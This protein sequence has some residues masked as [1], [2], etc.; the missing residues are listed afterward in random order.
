MRSH[1]QVTLVA[2]VIALGIN[3]RL[4]GA[5]TPLPY[6]DARLSTADR[7]RD[8]LGRMT[9]E[10]KFW[11]LFMIPGDLD[12]ASYDYS[13]RIFGLQISPADSARDNAARRHAERVNT[14]Q[15]YF[16]DRTR[17]G[18]P[19]IPFDE[20]LHGFVREGA[21]AF[22]QAI[23]LAATW[24]TALM[25]RVADAIAR[26]T[27]S[28]GVRQI[29]SPVINVANDVRWGRVEETY[30]EDPYLTSAMGQ[31]FIRPFE[32][33]GVITTAK[34]FI[35]NVGEGG[36]DSY[37]IDINERTLEELF[38]PPFRD[39]I[40]KA[41]GRSVMTAYNSVDGLPATQN[42]ALLNGKL[43]GDWGLQ[44]FVISD[45]AATGGATVLHYTEASTA[46]AVKDALDAGLEGLDPRWHP[47]A[48]GEAGRRSLHSGARA[49]HAR[50]RRRSGSAL[51][52]GR[53]WP[54]GSGA[55]R[56][57]LRDQ[58]AGGSGAR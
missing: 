5:Q 55:Q 10:E 31:A 30:G 6:R 4:A 3:A 26:E 51:V 43:K 27:R 46:T 29:L 15:R 11:Q 23:G 12:D 20:A 57:V 56:R 34:H 14:I 37:P 39:A 40:A 53:E 45:A 2:V 49:D 7:V 13:H 50:S 24:D 28:R 44:G 58:S 41:G 16:V 38:Y 33:A 32:R 48:G 17:L 21:T 36:R 22:P 47:R 1:R 54:H 52:V 19:I 9:R 8:L 18:I 42:R 25:G 35:A